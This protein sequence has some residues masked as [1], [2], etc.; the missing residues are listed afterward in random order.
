MSAKKTP[1]HEKPTA[2]P[3][4]KKKDELSEKD[5]DKASGGGAAK[6]VGD[7]SFSS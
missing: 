5:L 4:A 7:Y 6:E 1:K 2:K 3:T